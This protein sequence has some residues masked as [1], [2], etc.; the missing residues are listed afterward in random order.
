MLR[1]RLRVLCVSSM[2]GYGSWMMTAKWCLE[3][4]LDSLFEALS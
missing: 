3:V 1:L 2:V 4:R